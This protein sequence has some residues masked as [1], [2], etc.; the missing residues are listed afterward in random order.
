LKHPHNLKKGDVIMASDAPAPEDVTPSHVV[1]SDKVLGVPKFPLMLNRPLWEINAP[2]IN[3]VVFRK[4]EGDWINEGDPVVS[5]HV[6]N[7][8]LFKARVLAEVRSPISGRLIYK[9]GTAPYDGSKGEST[10]LNWLDFLFVIEIPKGERVPTTSEKAFGEFCN[11]LWEHREALLKKPFGHSDEHIQREFG[12]L[13]KL[14]PVVIFKN[15]G[16]WQEQID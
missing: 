1:F 2:D 3:Y 5:I 7:S 9:N 6:K 11:V 15:E 14:T 13:Q 8:T 4:R 10:I 16:D 12:A